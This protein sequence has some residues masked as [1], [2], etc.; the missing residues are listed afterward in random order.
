MAEVLHCIRI[1]TEWMMWHSI[2]FFNVLSYSY[3]FS[4]LILCI[5]LFLSLHLLH[6]C[7]ITVLICWIFAAA[8]SEYSQSSQQPVEFEPGTAQVWLPD[9]VLSSV[10]SI[11]T[12]VTETRN[13]CS[14]KRK[15][16]FNSR[17]WLNFSWIIKEQ[18]C[19]RLFLLSTAVQCNLSQLRQ[20]L[21]TYY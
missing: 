9:F 8:E 15:R 19:L 17:I 4:F 16:H 21:G 14:M 7:A 18:M 2:D 12:C 1:F 10:I 3:V 11:A 5:D 6:G 20:L 13:L